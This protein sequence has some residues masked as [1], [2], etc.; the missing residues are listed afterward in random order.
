[1]LILELR[2]NSVFLEQ[3][4]KRPPDSSQHLLDP[5]QWKAAGVLLPGAAH[6]RWSVYGLYDTTYWRVENLT[7]S[8]SIF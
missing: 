7:I 3:A 1:M 5:P 4:V 2:L 8:C 6:F